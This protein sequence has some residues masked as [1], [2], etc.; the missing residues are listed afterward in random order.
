V[1]EPYDV[2]VSYS[3]RYVVARLVG[4]TVAFSVGLKVVRTLHT[5]RQNRQ[6]GDAARAANE[7]ALELARASHRR[8]Y[9]TGDAKL[10][11]VVVPILGRPLLDAVA[12]RDSSLGSRLAA[13]ARSSGLVD[14]SQ[15]IEIETA[16]DAMRLLA[17]SPRGGGPLELVVGFDGAIAAEGRVGDDNAMFG[18]MAVRAERAREAVVRAVAFAQG[19]WEVIDTRDEVRRLVVVAVPDAQ[20][21]IWVEGELGSSLSMGGRTP[22]V[23]LAPSQPFELRRADLTA[24]RTIDQLVAELRRAFEL[25]GA[26][27]S[28]DRAGLLGR[29]PVVGWFYARRFVERLDGERCKPVGPEHPGG[30]GP[31]VVDRVGEDHEVVSGAQQP[32]SAP[33]R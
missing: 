21:K 5:W 6:D 29:R 27:A 8:G 16:A 3:N 14:H 28:A 17:S 30:G 23:L 13:T 19:A 26:G 1:V 10:R 7:R 11:T 31:G 32:Q 15:G 33:P 18:S 20:Q 12:L 2:D 24:E 4:L 22:E 25:A 9:M